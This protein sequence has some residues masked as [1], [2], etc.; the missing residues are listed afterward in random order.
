MNLEYT[1]T[2][3]IIIPVYN[4]EKTIERCVESL[5]LGKYHNIEII[6][7]EDCSKDN[8]W[9][10]C[11]E[12]KERFDN[13]IVYQNRKNSGPSHT[14]NKGI[15][16]ATGDFIMFVDS[17]DWVSSNYI[18]E[19][20]ELYKKN[21]NRLIISGLCF[22]D[23]ISGDKQDFIWNKKVKRNTFLIKTNDFFELEE[24]FHIQ[25]IFNKLFERDVII[26]NNIRFDIRYRMGEDFQFVLKYMKTAQIRECLIINKTLYY[27]IRYNN[28]SLMSKFGLVDNELGFENLK[29]LYLISGESSKQKY[30]KAVE[31]LKN[32]YLYHIVRSGLSKKEKISYIESIIQ[33]GNAKKYFDRYYYLFT[34]EKVFQSLLKLKKI[35]QKVSNYKT[36][37]LNNYVIKKQRKVFE[38]KE[39]TII[40]QNCIGGVFYHD[41]RSNFYS[42]TINL[43]FSCPDF[44]KFVL[45]LEYYL[46]CNLEIRWGEEY[47][48]GKLDDIT[49]YFM[50][51]NTCKEAKES[52]ERRKKRI[53]KE[54]IIVLSTDMELFT[55]ETF[56]E[57]KKI[58]YPKILFTA[59][60]YADPSVLYY[61]KYDNLGKVP[62][63]IPRREFYK[64]NMLVETIN[65]I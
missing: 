40:S 11:K 61:K 57:W 19:F 64:D 16:L 17:D 34:K 1:Y 9:E 56:K 23:N 26:D 52:W 49:I 29:N 13:I 8:S 59:N 39:I 44:I 37:F 47:P 30:E 65:N 14:R 18:S 62:N 12:L 53:N 55:K 54:K 7:I 27:Y 58:K 28:D 43:F 42:P 51:Y 31:N 4:A 10:V 46:S 32:N 60:Q 63:L 48:I 35:R 6:L 2:V 41:M 36:H 15:E 38:A 50:H 22:Y 21:K 45:N 25:S 24:K 3:S 33:D 20:L 5:A